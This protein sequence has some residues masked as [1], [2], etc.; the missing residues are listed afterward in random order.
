MKN[1]AEVQQAMEKKVNPLQIYET[2]MG[3]WGWGV[4]WGVQCCK[5]K[6]YAFFFLKR[7]GL[8]PWIEGVAADRPLWSRN[9][10]WTGVKGGVGD[11]ARNK[12][13]LL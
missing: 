4:E 6:S 5:K 10:L 9:K 1:D 11:L 13:P 2:L 12:I 3:G 8:W 7:T